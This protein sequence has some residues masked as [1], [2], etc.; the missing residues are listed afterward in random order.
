MIGKKEKENKNGNEAKTGGRIRY[1]DGPHKNPL[2][3]LRVLHRA[4]ILDGLFQSDCAAP[5]SVPLAE[6]PYKW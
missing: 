4:V 6:G 1:T 3:S 5:S 2:P